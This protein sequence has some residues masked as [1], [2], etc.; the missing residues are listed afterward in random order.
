MWFD[1]AADDSVAAAAFYRDLLGWEIAEQPNAGYQAWIGSGQPW[2][3]ITTAARGIGGRWLPYVVVA[4][5]ADAAKRAEQ[6]GA[7][8]VRPA[9]PW[10]SPTP[11]AP[12]WRCSHRSRPAPDRPSRCRCG[13][14]LRHRHFPSGDERDDKRRRPVLGTGRTA[15]G[16]RCGHP[17]HDDGLPVPSLPRPVLRLDRPYNRSGWRQAE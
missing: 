11:A 16:G 7:T 1:L 6:L 8:V 17:L 15:H 5:L 3:G 4:D 13:R 10:S 2:A 9:P 14:T 12:T